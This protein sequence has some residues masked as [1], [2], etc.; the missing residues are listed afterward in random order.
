PAGRA[1][2]ALADAHAT[3]T[4]DRTPSPTAPATADRTGETDHAGRA[5]ATAP[6]MVDGPD[7]DELAVLLN[8]VAFAPGSATPAHA[9]RASALAEQYVAALRAARPR[10]RRLL[11]SV[12]PGP[13]RWR[14]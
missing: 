7:V 6:A 8:Q 10:W 1:G 3:T 12:H 5:V 14:P 4:A 9:D 13:L 11:W 2:R